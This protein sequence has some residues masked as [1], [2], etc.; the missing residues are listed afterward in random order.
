ML[1]DYTLKLNSR[2]RK[3]LHRS[4]TRRPKESRS[5]GPTQERDGQRHV[6]NKNHKYEIMYS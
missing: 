6:L 3:T 2:D 4:V 1:E 5:Q